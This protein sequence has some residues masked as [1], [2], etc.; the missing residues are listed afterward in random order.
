M[1]AKAGV[2]TAGLLLGSYW[3]TTT[4]VLPKRE[5]N[6]VHP[7]TSWIPI[8]CYLVFRNM[9]HR[10]RRYHM[11]LFAWCGKVTLETYILQFHI[12]MK[13]T[14][15]NGSPKNLMIFVPGWYWTN[16]LI[17]ST[18]YIFVSFRVF[19]I[20]NTLKDAAIPKTNFLIAK[21][22]AVGLAVLA[23][24]YWMGSLL[25]SGPTPGQN[26]STVG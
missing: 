17:T 25:N 15:I 2:I 19:K 6:T 11:H 7:Y 24:F 9:S 5:Y 22:S 14:G 3:Y 26:P 13:T 1:A 20:T 21:H 12:W 16:M 10:L 23:A 4:F 8:L 18:I